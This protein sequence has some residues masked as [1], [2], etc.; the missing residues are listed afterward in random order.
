MFKNYIKISLRSFWKDKTFTALNSFGLAVAFGVSILLGV[1]ALFDLSTDKFHKNK[2]SIFQVYTITQT[3]KGAEASNSNPV[4]FAETLKE[5]VP[6]VEKATRYLSGGASFSYNEKTFEMGVSFVDTDFLSIFSF[7]VV[8]TLNL[9]PLESKSSIAIT[10]STARKVF[11]EEN[12]IGKILTGYLGGQEY[13]LTVSAVLENTPVQSSISFDALMN[14]KALPD[15][16]YANNLNSWNNH[17]NE[18]YIEL[19]KGVSVKQLEKSTNSFSNL[20]YEAEI[21]RNKGE[22]AKPDLLGQYMQIRLLPFADSSFVNYVDGVAKVNKSLQYLILAMAFLIV[23]IAGVNYVNMSIAKGAQRLKEIG[24]RK[25]LGANSKQLFFQF[26]GESLAIFIVSFLLGVGLAY[27]LLDKF[28]TLFQTQADFSLLL[29]PKIALGFLLCILII[30]LLAGGYPAFLMSKVETLKAL[31]GKIE[32]NGKNSLRNILIV[33]QFSIA[34]LFI[35]GTMVLWGQLDYMRSKDLGFS[36]EQVITLPLNAKKD[37]SDL[38]QLLRNKLE[39]QTGIISI[40]ASDNNLGLGK[41]GTSSKHMFG[42]VYKNRTVKTNMLHV[43]YDYVE[44]LGLNLIDGRDFNKELATDVLSVVINESMQKEL[45]EENP[46]GMQFDAQGDYKMTIIGVVKDYHFEGLSKAVE[47]LSLFMLPD[48]PMAYA[49]IKVAPNSLI[50]SFNKVESAW[51]EIEPGT[52]FLGSFLDENIERTFKKERRIITIISSSSILAII[53]SCIGLFA[54]SLLVV[55]QRRK[56]IGIR[57]VV[58]ASTFNITVLLSTDF[59][60]LVGIAFLIST[61]IAWFFSEKWLLTYA[62]KMELSVLIFLAAGILAMLIALATISLR[63]IQAASRNPVES[64]KS[65]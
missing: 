55:N 49:Y 19:A 16:I 15:G 52:R 45:G 1:Y 46:V 9:N 35:S 5:E 58:G 20:H 41:D 56:E 54:I 43:D 63:T 7:P 37:P 34:I 31:K 50:E 62:Y 29:S 60:K 8:E 64:L 22:G 59:L 57:K 61:P 14:F 40:S 47:P 23:F 6:G 44:T 53:L 36:K 26:W 25:T 51:K 18:V 17:N 65:E 33:I 32:N 12:P 13:P 30:S 48:E 38:I 4:P 28:Q 10:K 3:S 39:G 24:M 2:A 21:K 11:G 27:L 42:F